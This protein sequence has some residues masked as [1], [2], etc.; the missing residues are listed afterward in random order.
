MDYSITTGVMARGTRPMIRDSSTGFTKKQNVVV[1]TPLVSF[2]I[3]FV[4]MPI[5]VGRRDV[6][7]V[8]LIFFSKTIFG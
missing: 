6:R 5:H 2:T 7:W 8:K 1:G 4:Y 3:I